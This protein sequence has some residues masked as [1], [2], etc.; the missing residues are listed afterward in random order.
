MKKFFFFFAVVAI[1]QVC[2]GQKNNAEEIKKVL[3][4]QL[5]AWNAGNIDEFMKGYWQSDSLNFVGKTGVTYGWKQTL[6][7]YKKNYPDTSAMGKLAFTLLQIRKL[8]S[9]YYYVIGKWHLTRSV[10]DIGGSF[11]LLFRKIGGQWKIIS[12]HSS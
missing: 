12:D 1:Q 10:G 3:E 4:T 9:E 7:N 6:A 2:I 11:T 5:K 8:S